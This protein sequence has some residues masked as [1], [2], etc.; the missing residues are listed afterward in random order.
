MS[1]VLLDE[2]GQLVDESRPDA[3][4]ALVI[5]GRHP[6]D[7]L[8]GSEDAITAHDSRFGVE[9]TLESRCDFNRL[10]PRTEGLGERTVYGTFETFLEVVQNAHRSPDRVK[11]LCTC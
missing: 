10:Q 3:R 7:E 2:A 11:W 8:I 6:Y 9:F 5:A 4:H 1:G